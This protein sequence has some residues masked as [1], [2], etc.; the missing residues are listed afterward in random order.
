M[1]GVDLLRCAMFP[2]MLRI[3][4]FNG[5]FAC[6]QSVLIE[7]VPHLSLTR[8]RALIVFSSCVVLTTLEYVFVYMDIFSVVCWNNRGIMINRINKLLNFSVHFFFVAVFTNKNWYH[9]NDET[10]LFSNFNG[11]LLSNVN[12][13]FVSRIAKLSDFDAEYTLVSVNSVWC[14]WNKDKIRLITDKFGKKKITGIPQEEIRVWFLQTWEKKYNLRDVRS[15]PYERMQ[16]PEISLFKI[17]IKK[18]ADDSS[19]D[20]SRRGWRENMEM[21]FEW[22]RWVNKRTLSPVTQSKL[23]SAADDTRNWTNYY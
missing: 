22:F 16:K 15:S 9:E 4:N 17:R 5:S 8:C 10:T 6:S 14:M 2:A 7:N 20:M 1:Q 12:F 23:F 11:R 13:F 19:S 18:T 3:N 21:S